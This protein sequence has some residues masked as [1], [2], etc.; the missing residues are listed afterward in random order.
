M[1]GLLADLFGKIAQEI[2]SKPYQ[3]LTLKE[4][5]NAK[6]IWRD[7]T[8]FFEKFGG[9][10]SFFANLPTFGDRTNAIVDTVMQF[11]GEYRICSHPASNDRKA[12][13]RGKIT[14]IKNNLTPQPAEMTFPLNKAQYAID[15]DGTPNVLID[16][17]KPYIEHWKEAGGIA[18]EMCTD[19]FNSAHEVKQFLT[20]NLSAIK[21]ARCKKISCVSS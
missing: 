16:D 18:I 11:A 10:E 1:D 13:K 17:F 3:V 12:S 9:L 15:T 20:T 8:S 19:K 6:V 2:Y 7:K 4:K 14:W 5:L 21:R